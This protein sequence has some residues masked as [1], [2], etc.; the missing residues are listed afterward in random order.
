M[1]TTSLIIFMLLATFAKEHFSPTLVAGEE[2]RLQIE[3]VESPIVL[4]KDHSQRRVESLVV[5]ERGK[6]QA[7]PPDDEVSIAKVAWLLITIFG[8]LFLFP[9][10]MLFLQLRIKRMESKRLQ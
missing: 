7:A 9:G 3:N 1:K 4:S 10:L 5:N 8:V 6:T 2:T